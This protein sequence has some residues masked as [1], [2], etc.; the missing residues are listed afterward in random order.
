MGTPRPRGS[1]TATH[2][3]TNG[4]EEVTFRITG[5]SL[6][7]QHSP[8]AYKVRGTR[9]VNEI[10]TPED[11]AE[12][13]AYRNDDGSLY[14]PALWLRASLLRAASGHKLGKLTCRQVLAGGLRFA[15]ERLPL[16]DDSGKP[17]HDYVID[18]QRAVVQRQGI[19][20]ARPRI[21]CPWALEWPIHFN[22]RLISSEQI[23]EFLQLAGEICGIGD[24]RPAC[25][26]WFG[27]FSAEIV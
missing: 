22:P 24:Y 9:H 13:G 23:L 26:G 8:A 18:I 15:E 3:Q 21:N 19:L 17:I 20:R 25:N 6:L 12:D 27:R 4:L 5:T 14:V 10:P 16:L 7:L 1:A 2:E 11:E